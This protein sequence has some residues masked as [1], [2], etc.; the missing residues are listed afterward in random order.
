M[1]L[2]TVVD[3]VVGS[4]CRALQTGAP[5]RRPHSYLVDAPG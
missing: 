2:E 3:K 4:H 5:I 1:S